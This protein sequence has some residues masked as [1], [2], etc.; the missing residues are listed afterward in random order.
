MLKLSYKNETTT[1]NS[2]LLNEVPHMYVLHYNTMIIY[3]RLPVRILYLERQCSN[4]G[5]RHL[6]LGG[7]GGANYLYA[8]VSTHIGGMLLQGN[9]EI[10]CSESA[11]EATFGPKRHYSY[12]CYLYVFVRRMKSPNF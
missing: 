5:R 10:R 6:R 1:C 11:S 4:G 2:D 12:R 8:C 7:G 9:F 3:N